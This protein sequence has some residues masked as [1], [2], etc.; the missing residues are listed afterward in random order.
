MPHRKRPES[1]NGYY[2]QQI[3]RQASLFEIRLR[4]GQNNV[5]AFSPHYD[6]LQHLCDELRQTLNL[7]N[8]RPADYREPHVGFMANLPRG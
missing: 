2:I 7:L 1:L 4:E 6:A 8:G 3:E 5:R